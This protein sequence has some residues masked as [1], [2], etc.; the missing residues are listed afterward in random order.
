MKIRGLIVLLFVCG[1]F[2]FVLP[3][4]AQTG[5]GSFGSITENLA[6]LPQFGEVAPGV[7]GL[8]SNDALIATPSH[9][10]PFQPFEVEVRTPGT[11]FAGA[12]I[13]WYIDGEEDVT[14]RNQRQHTLLAKGLGEPTRIRV[15]LTTQNGQQS[16][17]TLTIVP[18]Q[19]DI[20]LESFS[21]VP[22]FYAGRALPTGNTI[23]R[24][25]A[26][27]N[28]GS[29][30]DRDDL[31][32]E[33]RLNSNVLDNGPIRGLRAVNFEVPLRGEQYLEVLIS[34]RSGLIARQG[35]TFVPP[36]PEILF[37]EDNP[38]RGIIPIALKEDASFSGN[39]VTLRAEPYYLNPSFGNPDN[40]VEW[41]L[42][43]Q[44]IDTSA[45]PER[46]V[47]TLR[48]NGSVSEGLVSVRMADLSV[49]SM[50]IR[51]SIYLRFGF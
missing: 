46:H 2:S 48:S 5:F 3:V 1:V 6:P 22:E 43:G 39:Q 34:D 36:E 21:T 17:L 35:T 40:L 24:A 33:W 38:V 7:S 19:V 12:T 51:K 50:P 14:A 32:Y 25:V 16:E 11:N 8:F 31:T 13:R 23:G 37:Y 49:L 41:N 45:E 20:V 42:G 27:I 28:T 29:T 30:I 15:D 26:T 10:A 4:S 47:V 18:V 44:A 9:P